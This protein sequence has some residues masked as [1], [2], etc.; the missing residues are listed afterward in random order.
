M[1]EKNY[2]D[3]SKDKDDYES[4][5]SFD[6][7]V[8]DRDGGGMDAVK[9]DSRSSKIIDGDVDGKVSKQWEDE[10]RNSVDNLESLVQDGDEDGDG[11][12]DAPDEDFQPLQK[13]K[14]EPQSRHA[15]STKT[16]T[17]IREQQCDHASKKLVRKRERPSTST[18]N[19]G[20]NN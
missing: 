19:I 2:I 9:A 12:D 13:T 20:G 8:E 16:D 17:D 1:V 18:S 6:R 3:D 4:A 15:S 7:N 5:K 10:E 11:D 14:R